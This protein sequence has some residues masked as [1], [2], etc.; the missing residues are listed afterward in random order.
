MSHKVLTSF[1]TKYPQAFTVMTAM[2]MI[3]K[4]VDEAKHDLK[5]DKDSTKYLSL[6]AEA[7]C[8]MEHLFAELGI[9]PEQLV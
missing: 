3:D 9:D 5:D 1:F 8:M 4:K 2:K 7:H 6:L